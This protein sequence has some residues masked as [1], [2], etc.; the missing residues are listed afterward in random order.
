MGGT[1]QDRLCEASAGQDNGSLLLRYAGVLLAGW[2]LPKVMGRQ[3]A[4][5][6]STGQHV[7]EGLKHFFTN[8]GGTVERADDNRALCGT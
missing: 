4:G 7:W 1:I 8:G 2:I 3:L 5:P 6:E